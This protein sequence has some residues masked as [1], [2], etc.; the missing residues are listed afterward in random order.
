MLV[1]ICFY[2]CVELLLFFGDH[3]NANKREVNLSVNNFFVLLPFHVTSQARVDKNRAEA[4]RRKYAKEAWCLGDLDGI[5]MDV[6]FVDGF[7]SAV[8]FCSLQMI[9]RRWL[10]FSYEASACLGLRIQRVQGST[11]LHVPPPICHSSL[12]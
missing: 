8:L 2:R 3:S 11:G 1:P 9:I 12:S 6:L 7:T 10:R 5:V 4:L